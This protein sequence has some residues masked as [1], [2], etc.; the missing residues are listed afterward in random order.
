MSNYEKYRQVKKEAKATGVL[1]AALVLFWLLAGFG[2]S[3]AKIEL[4]GLP[5]WAIMGT[6][7]VWLFA[8]VGVRVLVKG[9]FRDMPLS[10]E[11]N[12]LGALAG[13]KDAA[14][15]GGDAR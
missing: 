15:E 14:S 7:G 3:G 13:G 2:L 1:L 10:D 8:I 11:G 5:L 12:P 6:L 9:F 4:F